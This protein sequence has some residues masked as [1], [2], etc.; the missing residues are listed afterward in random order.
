MREKK[1]R[2]PNSMRER[3]NRL[4]KRMRERKNRLP[5]REKGRRVKG[6]RE[7]DTVIQEHLWGPLHFAQDLP[8]HACDCGWR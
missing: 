6:E 7:K 1:N 8:V 2:L 4:P 3:K 5:V